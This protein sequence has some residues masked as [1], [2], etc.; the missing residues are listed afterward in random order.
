LA[1]GIIADLSRDFWIRETGTG[2]Q[3]AHLHDRYDDD[4]D[5]D[6]AFRCPLNV[7]LY[8]NTYSDYGYIRHL[9]LIEVMQLGLRMFIFRLHKQSA[10][11][12]YTIWINGIL[13]YIDM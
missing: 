4:D 13:L 5:D 7:K 8:Q 6:G 3:V 12:L 2:Q 1:E 11:V 9:F 10:Q